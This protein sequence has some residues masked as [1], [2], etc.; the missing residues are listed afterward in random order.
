MYGFSKRVLLAFLA[1]AVLQGWPDR[2]LSLDLA[3]PEQKLAVR[4][5]SHLLA[6]IPLACIVLLKRWEWP[7]RRGWL[8][9]LAVVWL[10]TVPIMLFPFREAGGSS[11]LVA[12]PRGLSVLAALAAPLWLSLLTMLRA[13]E[14]VVPRATAGAAIAGIAGACLLLPGAT[15]TLRGPR[16]IPGTLLVIFGAIGTVWS[17]SFAAR[18]LCNG[19]VISIAASAGLVAA[20]TFALLS[21]LIERAHWERVDLREVAAPLLID[22]FL[23]TLPTIVLW[24]WV[25]RKMPLPAFTLQAIA[26]WFVPSLAGFA[27]FGFRAFRVDLAILLGIAALVV[28]L[29]ARPHDDEFTALNL[30]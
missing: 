10:P 8:A 14:S 20:S 24:Y 7:N 2:G 21:F 22:A 27:L 19:H 9:I 26:S 4:A 1:L 3:M 29:R 15:M 25:L 5:F 30:A 12:P 6:V 16:E 11:P 17:W 23:F 13:S 18:R 28:G